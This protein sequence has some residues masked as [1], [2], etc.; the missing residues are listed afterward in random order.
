MTQAIPPG[1]SISVRYYILCLVDLLSQRS[2][3]ARWSTLPSNGTLTPEL[4]QGIKKTVGSVHGIKKNFCDFFA[5][6]NTRHAPPRPVTP[7]Q[8]VKYLRCR[9]CKL[10]VQQ[11]SD[12]IIFYSPV[13]NSHGDFSAEAFYRTIAACALILNFSLAG[14]APLRGAVCIGPGLELEPN[15]FYGPALARAHHLEARWRS[16]HGL[17]STTKWLI[18]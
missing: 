8:A 4:I 9:E 7:E 2:H 18:F 6:L 16:I 15:N 17:L 12:T 13:V 3:L 14:K 11:F 5:Q 1:D 10:S